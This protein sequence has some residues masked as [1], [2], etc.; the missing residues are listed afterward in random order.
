MES[1]T[2]ALFPA[3]YTTVHLALFRE[4]ENAGEVRKRLI[5]AATMSGPEGEEA[6]KSVEFGFIDASVVSLS[7]CFASCV[8]WF[9]LACLAALNIAC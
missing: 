2:L 8:N 6:R 4:I 9:L 1:Y 3:P 7:L 5:E